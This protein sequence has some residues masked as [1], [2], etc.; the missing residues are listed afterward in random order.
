[1]RSVRTPDGYFFYEQRDGKWSD[2]PNIEKSDMVFDSIEQ[3]EDEI[4]WG[5]IHEEK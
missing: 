1:M 4:N 3:L 2:H 5:L